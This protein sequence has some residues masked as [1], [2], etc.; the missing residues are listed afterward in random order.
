MLARYE[1]SYAAT[2]LTVMGDRTVFESS[3]Q[4][5]YNHI[6]EL[7]DGKLARMKITASGL[8]TDEEFLRRI[9]LDL[10][11]LP[12]TAE[13]VRT[14]LADQ[15]DSRA[16]RAASVVNVSSSRLPSAT[17]RSNCGSFAVG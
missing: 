9:H 14:F 16:K 5:V 8:Y 4:P 15:R 3:P 13:Q 2:T 1:G 6:D 10:T 12:P 11:G 17:P 7:V